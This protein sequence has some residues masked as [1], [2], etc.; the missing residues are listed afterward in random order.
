MQPYTLSFV[1]V[2]FGE[3]NITITINHYTGTTGRDKIGQPHVN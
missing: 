3:L 2:Y 1:L